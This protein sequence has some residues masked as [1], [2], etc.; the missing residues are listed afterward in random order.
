MLIVNPTQLRASNI[1][2]LNRV[3]SNPTTAPAVGVGSQVHADTINA[4]NRVYSNPT[5][6]PALQGRA[7]PL[8][9]TLNK[10]YSNPTTAPVLQ[11]RASSPNVPLPPEAKINAR[12]AQLEQQTTRYASSRGTL[13]GFGFA[14]GFNA[15]LD[16]SEARQKAQAQARNEWLRTPNGQAYQKLSNDYIDTY[17]GSGGLTWERYVAALRS[18]DGET[19]T[20]FAKLKAQETYNNKLQQAIDAYQ[21]KPENRRKLYDDGVAKG[22][23][24]PPEG[25]G[26][27]ALDRIRQNYGIDILTVLKER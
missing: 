1:N 21:S 15:E 8:I 7:S 14:A 17:G 11:G 2:A 4:L 9:N 19:L 13:T 23:I 24:K 12:A 18:Q 10:I 26:S 3:Y 5:T 22:T 27:E 6:A 16:K 20:D 25:Y